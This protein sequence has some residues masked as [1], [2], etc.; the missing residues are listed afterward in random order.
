MSSV[1][2]WLMVIITAIYVGATILICR[3]N[4]KSVKASKEELD[5]MKRQYSE[6]NRPRIEVE[7]CYEKKLFF[8]L[9]LV[10][11]GKLNAQHVKIEIDDEFINNLPEEN[12]KELLLAQKQKEGIIGVSQHYDLFIATNRLRENSD[13]KPVTGK[14]LYQCDGKSYETPIYID[15]ANYLTIFSIAEKNPVENELINI[16]KEIAGL[17]NAVESS[18]LLKNEHNNQ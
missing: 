1:T 9:R 8:F 12:C 18:I 16:K 15:I 10:N 4:I 14:V 11:H 3:A 2:D 17:K 5:E 6:E 13:I 7:L